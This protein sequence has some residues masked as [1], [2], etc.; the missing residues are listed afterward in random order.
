MKHAHLQTKHGSRA[1]L[2][3]GKEET[4]LSHKGPGLNSHPKF[5]SFAVAF[6]LTPASPRTSFLYKDQI[7]RR[8]FFSPLVFDSVSFYPECVVYHQ[9]PS[10]T[11]QIKYLDSATQTK[12]VAIVFNYIRQNPTY[13]HA[14]TPDD[15]PP[16]TG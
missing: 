5:L 13:H 1:T 11:Q 8:P 4:A 15:E 12:Q 9:G 7:D 10:H 6:R 2:S 16:G 14:T 3:T